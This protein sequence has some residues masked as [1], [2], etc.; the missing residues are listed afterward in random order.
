[1][2]RHSCSTPG[3]SGGGQVLERLWLKQQAPN[4]S[5]SSLQW[6][7]DSRLACGAQLPHWAHRGKPSTAAKKLAKRQKQTLAIVQV[8]VILV[9][10][11]VAIPNQSSKLIMLDQLS[12][13]PSYSQ[14]ILGKWLQSHD[15]ACLALN[16]A[17]GWRGTRR[18]LHGRKQ[19]VPLI[20]PW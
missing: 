18:F 7:W 16:N 2:K 12:A 6:H 1:M 3:S 10:A 14:A 8:A 13:E 15:H 17:I 20:F 4:I 5:Q 19:L 11:E 9:R